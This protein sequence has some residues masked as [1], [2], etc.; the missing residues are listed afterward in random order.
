[1]AWSQTLMAKPNDP[2]S[3]FNFLVEIDG[4]IRAGFTEVSG[5]ESDT[6]VMEY[7]EGSDA[8]VRRKLPGLTKYSNVT[9]KRGV[10]GDSFLWNW[11]KTVTDGNTK[12]LGVVI[13]LLDESRQ[14]VLRWKLFR[15]WPKKWAGPVLNAKTSEV[16]IEELELAHEGLEQE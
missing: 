14:E 7:R 16:A 15:A 2:Y 10:T 4:A 6:E 9:L 13:I 1:M 8:N 12:R 11:R 5:I 3:A